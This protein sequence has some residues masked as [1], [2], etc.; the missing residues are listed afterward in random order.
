M[1][2]KQVR[3]GSGI[4]DKELNEPWPPSFKTRLKSNSIYICDEVMAQVKQT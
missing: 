1:R 2:V 4:I 3:Y